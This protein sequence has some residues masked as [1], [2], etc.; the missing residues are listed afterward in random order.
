MFQHDDTACSPQHFSTC[1]CSPASGWS[2]WGGPEFILWRQKDASRTR[3]NEKLDGGTGPSLTFWPGILPGLRVILFSA[4]PL[5]WP[6]IECHLLGPTEAKL[7]MAPARERRRRHVTTACTTCRERRTK[8]S[9]RTRL[10]SRAT[11]SS[12]IYNDQQCDGCRP[13]CS[14]CKKRK[15]D[16]VYQEDKRRHV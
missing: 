10:P 15:G 3:G 4:L 6:G 11:G 5:T 14:S 16:C 12:S 2:K 8:V 7:K 9:S 1:P 13:K